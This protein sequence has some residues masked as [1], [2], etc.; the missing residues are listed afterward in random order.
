[1]SVAILSGPPR[2]EVA[3]D[4]GLRFVRDHFWLSAVTIIEIRQY[5]NGWKCFE[6]SG[7]EPVFLNQQDAISYAED[8]A[9]FRSGEIC[10][11]D[12]SGAVTNIVPFSEVNRKLQ[13]E[14]FPRLTTIGAKQSNEL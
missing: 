6:A 14:P 8:R 1:M 9:W 3:L 11:F 13:R 12:S 7:V 10:V 2:P 5:R 4:F